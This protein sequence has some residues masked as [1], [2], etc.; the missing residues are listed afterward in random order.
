MYMYI[1][2]SLYIYIYMYIYIYICMYV[3]MYYYYYYYY[4]AFARNGGKLRSNHMNKTATEIANTSGSCE[5]RRT[6]TENHNTA[7]PRVIM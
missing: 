7:S 5:K 4:L 1:S 6:T 3:C 2:L